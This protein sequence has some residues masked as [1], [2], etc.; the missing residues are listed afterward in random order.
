MTLFHAVSVL[1][2]VMRTEMKNFDR[3][4]KERISHEA[5]K[6]AE[7]QDCIKIFILV[8]ML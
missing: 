5:G 2:V 3:F 1:S 6:R 4:L 7:S 8:F